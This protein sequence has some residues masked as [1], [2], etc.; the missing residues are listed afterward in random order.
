MSHF[1]PHQRLEMIRPYPKNSRGREFINRVLMPHFASFFRDSDRVLYV[2][3]QPLWDY[4]VF[5]NGPHKQA[6]FITSDIEPTVEP[7]VVDNMADSQFATDSFD[8]VILI[9]LFDSMKG[10]G[11]TAKKIVA[12]VHRVLRPGGRLFA[13][14]GGKAGGKYDPVRA[15]PAFYVDEVYYIWGGPEL[16]E[17]GADCR[18][19]G[20]NHAIFLIMRSKSQ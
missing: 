11:T 12:E 14:V 8:G 19:E 18:G 13:A 1:F 6:E 16:V 20:A 3:K 7:D 2:G 15:W 9:G 5:F 10:E 4:S 17:S